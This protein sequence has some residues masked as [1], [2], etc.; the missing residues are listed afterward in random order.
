[1]ASCRAIHR[2][3]L[4]SLI[5][6]F[7]DLGLAYL[8][9]CAASLVFLASKFLSFF[10]LS[11]PCPCNGFFG[12]P[13]PA[14]C[15]QSLLADQPTARIQAVH[16]RIRTLS[17]FVGD[18][19]SEG[20]DLS[21]Q[22]GDVNR[23]RN[24]SR[25]GGVRSGNV[26]PRLI[27][28]LPI[29]LVE[30]ERETEPGSGSVSGGSSGERAVDINSVS[31]DDSQDSSMYETKLEQETAE[32][33]PGSTIQTL[34]QALEKERLTQIALTLELEKERN[35]SS[36]AADEAMAMI[37]RLQKEKSEIE[38]EARQYKR[39]TEEKSVYDLEEME[40]LKEIIVRRE[41]ENFALEKEL[42]ECHKL[43]SE[44]QLSGENKQ[45]DQDSKPD[46]ESLETQDVN[47]SDSNKV[48][49]LE[50][51]EENDVLVY[52]VHVVDDKSDKITDIRDKITEMP[53][54]SEL[55]KVS[56]GKETERASRSRKKSITE[57]LR[58]NSEPAMYMEK[59]KLENEVE[60]LRKRLKLIQHEREKLGF[61]VDQNKES[62]AS[63]LRLLEEISRQLEEIKVSTET[64]QSSR[65]GSIPHPSKAK[66]GR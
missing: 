47:A 44:A 14:I 57:N 2:W 41:M 34:K 18:A 60:M 36:S 24:R 66:H 16:N 8:F 29:E 48:V 61:S 55:P 13:N 10:H 65:Q 35:A 19:G 33:D 43:I 38:I 63:Q 11:L 37:L 6:A 50:G 45:P 9:L 28:S 17:P 53:L 20:R 52:D 64:G 59:F 49:I 4:C 62:E 42:E 32:N 39:M 1:M 26:N 21:V 27:P 40:I 54:I 23:G 22:V 46:T 31:E 15:V 51:H 25:S 30:V 58:R 3:S 7:L 56:K 12:H 5:G